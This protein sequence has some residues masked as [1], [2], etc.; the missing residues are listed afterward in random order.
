[1]KR[2]YNFTAAVFLIIFAL[3]SF[4]IT[5]TPVS[6]NGHLHVT[7]LQLMNECGYPVQLRGT[8]TH[9]I[10]WFQ[11]C[12][13]AD[14]MDFLANVMKS[15]MIRIA[16][17]DYEGNGNS[18]INNPD[19]NTVLVKS[20]VDMATARG[21]YA[22]I[23][24]HILADGDPNTNK[25]YAAT[26]FTEMANTYKNN[27][28][29]IYEICNEPNG[30]AVTWAVIKTYAQY[31]IPIIRAIDPN[32]VIIVGTPNWSQLGSDVVASQ[33]TFPNIMYTF[34]FYA[35]THDTSKLTNYIDSLPIFCTEWGPSD[36]SGNGGDNYVRAADYIDIMGGNNSAGVKISWAEWSLADN[37]DS[38]SMFLPG[39]C[40]SGVYDLSKLS[41]AG[42]FVYTNMN[43]PAKSFICG[44][45]TITPTP[46]IYAGTPTS[47]YTVTITPTQL[48]W[49]LIYNGDTTGYTLADGVAVANAMVN[50]GGAT[51]AGT[52]TETTGGNPGNGMYL[53]YIGQSWWEG[54]SWML[55]TPKTI[56]TNNY[57]E[58]EIKAVSG[59]AAQL[60]LYLGTTN[61]LYAGI[62]VSNQWST[63][64][65][66]LS[67]LY[68]SMPAT[69]DEIDF[70]SNYNQNYAVM[71]DNIRLISVPTNTM[72]VTKTVTATFT[73]T[74]TFT[75][76]MTFT[77]TMTITQTWTP[78]PSFTV[79]PTLT[80]TLTPSARFVDV[81]QYLS[82][83]NPTTGDKITFRY[84]ITGF[85][86]KLTINVYTFGDR[87]I[88]SAVQTKVSQGM[89]TEVWI[90]SM[91][92]AN[93]L[94]YYSIEGI[95]GTRPI[96]RHVSAFFVHRD[97]PMP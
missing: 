81:S 43:N 33:L 96:S 76:T 74:A 17:Y 34:H 88:Y 8:S 87:K 73:K 93:G 91:K 39:T 82:Y 41:T 14:M 32:A 36:S 69:V 5:A 59:T 52:I 90:P 54:H 78:G 31:I 2:T 71:V 68:S 42:N 56:G 15:D 46:T 13:T 67:S 1:M 37:A 70:L 83:P 27:N 75:N 63:V 80:V 23:D 47:T 79:T 84:L 60:R 51:Q 16:M 50:N 9:G 20:L 19:A 64:R 97:I 22:V 95:N 58:F 86:E 28:N 35:G 94:Y 29:V 6:E 30:S 21:M 53:N 24:W 66:P 7:G 89:H 25:T 48:P 4:N 92:L 11:S 55:N 10:M 45:A 44:T 18:Y 40:G 49:D 85:A 26:F 3:F 57:M 62:N 61:L 77:K 38:S 12:Y 72:T 65:I